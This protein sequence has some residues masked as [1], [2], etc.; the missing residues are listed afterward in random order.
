MTKAELG[1]RVQVDLSGLQAPGIAIGGGVFAIGEIVGIDPAEHE[2]TVQL[3][4]L[5][6]ANGQN[7]VTAPVSHIA[8]LPESYAVPA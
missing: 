2:I 6:F 3:E 5:S 8:L 1:Q 4:D 7:V